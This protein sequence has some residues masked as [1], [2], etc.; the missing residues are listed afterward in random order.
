MLLIRLS[1]LR[2][3]GRWNGRLPRISIGLPR[4][5]ATKTPLDFQPNNEK[6]EELGQNEKSD[7][8][9]PQIGA[10]QNVNSGLSGMLIRFIQHESQIL[11]E[12]M[13]IEGSLE[14]ATPIDLSNV[15]PFIRRQL[16]A[17]MDDYQRFLL[18][19]TFHPISVP[20][21]LMLHYFLTIPAVLPQERTELLKY[22]IFHNLWY[23]F[24]L[25]AVSDATT[26]SDVEDLMDLVHVCLVSNN[27]LD[28]G[29]WQAL[30]A[31]HLVTSN[32]GLLNTIGENAEFRLHLGKGSVDK[33]YN[34][35]FSIQSAPNV[36]ALKHALSEN[37]LA[38]NLVH[39]A[40]Y[41]RK[42]AG[43]ISPAETP[44]FLNF[45]DAE[46]TRTA[47]F[48]SLLLTSNGDLQLLLKVATL[49]VADRKSHLNDLDY[50][51]I[52]KTSPSQLYP[53]YLSMCKNIK[54]RLV[55]SDQIV[56]LL[57]DQSLHDPA[58]TEILA[59][60]FQ[61]A[62][63]IET[64]TQLILMFISNN[65]VLRRLRKSQPAKFQKVVDAFMA[66]NPTLPDKTLLALIDIS[67]GHP[68][69]IRKIL[70]RLSPD[71]ANLRSLLNFHLSAYNLLEVM[72]YA[73]RHQIINSDTFSLVDRILLE[74]WDVES[75]SR[76][77]SVA[78]SEQKMSS[79]LHKDDFRMYYRA[80]TEKD[81]Q[82]LLFNLQA[83]AQ[84][85]SLNSPSV[86]ASILNGLK[87][88]MNLDSFTFVKSTTGRAYIFDRL[89]ARTMHFIYK[90][91]RH[92]AKEGVMVIRKVLSHLDFDSTVTQA[93]LFEHIVYDDPHICIDILKNY[94]KNK[95]F[96][97]TPL[98]E[99]IQIG[100]LRSSKLSPATRLD[101][102]EK[103]RATM[104]ELGYKSKM[105]ARTMARFGDLIFKVGQG[106]GDTEGLGWVVAMGYDRGV[107]L[108]VIKNWSRK[109]HG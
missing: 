12:S 96:L 20:P 107:P 4:N 53:V 82:A 25:V 22:L 13:N 95:A 90:N 58:L 30:A 54:R 39:R 29:L 37:D 46:L 19:L 55:K 57:V 106:R 66:E 74:T 14:C 71:P 100:I 94:R 104:V 35:L 85:I 81:R 87:K 38:S 64:W 10:K 99:A 105:S 36:A 1:L 65:Q 47:G 52:L 28:L 44:A 62:L 86:T 3:S 33:F 2:R 101:L 70:Q 109:L 77:A 108:K 9:S 102:F 98:M 48:V 26:M 68:R 97:T 51:C 16:D 5:Y 69:I 32:L 41:L 80:S 34:C 11:R 72:R 84:T 93:A 63:S 79:E 78:H 76:Q 92:T 45:I 67:D 50:F 103:F 15:P 61:R 59:N 18:L 73:L 83:L 88:Y 6:I 43:L 7:S 91:H 89:A 42:M 8:S 75:L 56:S 60:K 40:F 23:D 21:H 24:W 27:N 31:A 17:Q 49:L